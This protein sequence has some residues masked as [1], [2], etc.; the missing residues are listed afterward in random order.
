MDILCI[1]PSHG[2]LHL[3]SQP[4]NDRK[5]RKEI[6]AITDARLLDLIRSR[7]GLA[8]QFDLVWS[9]WEGVIRVPERLANGDAETWKDRIE[10]IKQRKGIFHHAQIR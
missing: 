7:G 8:G 4:H 9:K 3:P 5:R 1:H 10:N 2:Y 6:H